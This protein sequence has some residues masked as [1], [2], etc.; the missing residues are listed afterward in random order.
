V[1]DWPHT[2]WL[3][4]GFFA[5]IETVATN[6]Y[7]DP[8][9]LMCVW[10]SESGMRPTAE[11]PHGHASGIFQA[12]PATLRG[13]G[14]TGA[15]GYAEP[16]GDYAMAAHAGDTVRC[17]RLNAL[18]AASYRS[19]SATEELVWAER[20]YRPARGKL[21]SRAAIYLWTFVPADIGLASNPD[22]VITAKRGSSLCPEGRRANIFDINAGFDANGDHATVVHELDDAIDRA[23]RGPLWDELEQR[24]RLQLGLEPSVPTGTGSIPDLRTVLGVQQVLELL[25][26]NPGT[27]DG[28]IGPRTRA[29]I[30]MFQS[31]ALIAADGVAGPITR[32]AL[33]L[34]YDGWRNDQGLP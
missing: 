23:C 19:L 34:A 27:P 32:N 14:F 28:H 33:K 4:D 24:E 25:G 29:A 2:A 11:N 15:N 20:Y 9:N 13:L 21:V 6:L 1:S 26:Y 16:A 5:R 30:A 18:L 3:D 17:E 22:A 12:M 31:H 10:M 7:A 8:F